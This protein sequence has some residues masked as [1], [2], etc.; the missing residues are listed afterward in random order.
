[1]ATALLLRVTMTRRITPMHQA[2]ALLAAVLLIAAGAC[3]LDAGEHPGKDLCL[4][5]VAV[6]AVSMPGS[7]L[8]LAGVPA[9][10]AA[11]ASPLPRPDFPSP[12]PRG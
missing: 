11:L 9:P 5:H 2:I 3:L 8:A 7:L 10:A 12:P 1:L 6:T 4:A